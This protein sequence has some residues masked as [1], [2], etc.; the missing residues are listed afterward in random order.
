MDINKLVCDFK[1]VKLDT[2]EKYKE[3]ISSKTKE[4]CIFPPYIPLIGKKYIKFRILIYA[5]A[6]NMSHEGCVANSYSDLY[7]KNPTNL[8]KRL[9]YSRKDA[10][11]KCSNNELKFSEVY[12]QPWGTGILPA[13][14]GLFLNA[15]CN[16]QFQKFEEI[17]DHVA[18]TNYYKFS[19]RKGKNKGSKDLNPNS[20]DNDV[21]FEN[22]RVLNDDLVKRE[23][24]ELRPKH[25]LVFGQRQ[26]KL[27]NKIGQQL[28]FQVRRVNDT[29]WI[30]RGG[31]GCLKSGKRGSW[32]REVKDVL[33]DN[34][35]ADSY[36]DHL[37]KPYK[38]RKNEVRV[39]LLKYYKDW[40]KEVT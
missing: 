10:D 21:R 32:Y 20:F 4:G 26:L 18:V 9:Y 37:K 14:V 19:L 25:V 23:I 8:V 6:Q 30:L 7:K 38:R 39:Y 22:Y 11:F 34:R 29:A 24:A 33:Y 28:G 17:Q 2:L 5:T 1:N 36:L 13:L 31:S 16:Q 15:V 27:L 3:E 12:I 40:C 35:M